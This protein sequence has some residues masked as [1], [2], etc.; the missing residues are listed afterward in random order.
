MKCLFSWLNQLY[1]FKTG[2]KVLDV[3]ARNGKAML[4]FERNG[5]DVYGIEPSELFYKKAFKLGK[6]RRADFYRRSK[7][8]LAVKPDVQCILQNYSPGL[9]L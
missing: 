8:K 2:S 3:G 4:A 1:Q 5:Y 6:T 7:F 9:H